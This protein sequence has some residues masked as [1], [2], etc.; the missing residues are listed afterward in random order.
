[1]RVSSAKRSSERAASSPIRSRTRSR[2]A[3]ASAPGI[4]GVAQQVLELVEVAEILHGLHRRAESHRVLALEVVGLLPAH[5]GEHLLE[6]PPSWSSCQRGPCRRAAAR[7]AAGAAPAVGRHRVQHRL[8]GRHPRA[9]C[10]SS[11]SRFW[12]FSGKKSPNC[13]MNSRTVD[14]RPLTSLEHLVERRQHVLHALHVGGRHFCIASDIWSTICC[15]SCS[16][17][18]SISC[19]NR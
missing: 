9:I 14:L 17:S 5:L 2:S 13:C 16:R 3:S 18:R 19:S 10:S 12:G 15:I 6:V 4:G 1:M 11:S 8:H 7:S